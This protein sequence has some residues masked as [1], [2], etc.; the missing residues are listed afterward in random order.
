MKY[1]EE[2]ENYAGLAKVLREPNAEKVKLN[3]EEIFEL[4]IC[5]GTL[6]EIEIMRGLLAHPKSVAALGKQLKKGSCL[7]KDS[8]MKIVKE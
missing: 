7:L 4:S 5:N 3:L 2:I 6:E 8:L 1:L